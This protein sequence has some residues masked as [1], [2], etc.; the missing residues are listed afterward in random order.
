MKTLAAL[1]LP[2]LTA[3]L[4]VSCAS[5]SG[6][7]GPIESKISDGEIQ[8][9]V[10]IPEGQSLTLAPDIPEPAFSYRLTEKFSFHLDAGIQTEPGGRASGE[11]ELLDTVTGETYTLLFSAQYP[12][13]YMI[14]DPARSH[15]TGAVAILKGEESVGLLS[16]D[17]NRLSYPF[18]GSWGEWQFRYGARMSGSPYDVLDDEGHAAMLSRANRKMSVEFR[19][20]LSEDQREQ[21]MAVYLLAAE[22]QHFVS[23]N[24]PDR[25]LTRSRPRTNLFFWLD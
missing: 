4:V 13:E 5:Q 8:S 2:L 6:L 12:D 18:E 16:Y 1:S 15:A 24:A 9:Y 3:L 23:L 10:L 22:L 19:H 11:Y 7:R 21:V 25:A 20:D 17:R 14:N